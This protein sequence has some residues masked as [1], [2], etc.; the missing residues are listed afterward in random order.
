MKSA[1]DANERASAPSATT[2]E[3]LITHSLRLG[4]LFGAG[5]SRE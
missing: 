4:E 2:R 5:L 1:A 3:P